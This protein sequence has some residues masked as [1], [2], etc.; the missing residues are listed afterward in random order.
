MS[1]F[2]ISNTAGSNFVDDELLPPTPEQTR[3]LREQG[4]P[5]AKTAVTLRVE[6]APMAAAFVAKT[7][8][9]GAVS[10]A[11]F[12][13]ECRRILGGYMP[14][15]E[16]GRL[17][18]HYTDFIKRNK[19]QASSIR[20]RILTYLRKYDLSGILGLETRFNREKDELTDAKLREIEQAA[21]VV[22]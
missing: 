5:Y 2:P 7:Q 11:A 10:Q 13:S 14:E 16:K 6:E 22:R 9:A 15:G 20:F 8:A 3:Y 4:N 17:R 21:G 1:K 12:D 19:A 18:P